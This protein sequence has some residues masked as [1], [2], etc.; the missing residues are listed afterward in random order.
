MAAHTI[1][2]KLNWENG[3]SFNL[4]SKIDAEAEITIMEIT[5]NADMG[6]VWNHAAELCLSYIR[7]RLND[8]GIEMM[9]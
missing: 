8:I 1:E 3:M 6:S 7:S 4:K 2:I 5:E 9:A